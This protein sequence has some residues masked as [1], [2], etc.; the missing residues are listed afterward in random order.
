MPKRQLERVSRAALIRLVFS[1]ALVL[2]AACLVLSLTV[3]TDATP[4]RAEPFYTELPG[5]DFS[6]LSPE[7]KAALLKRLNR[8]RCPCDCMRTVASCRNHHDSCSMSLVEARQ[9]VEAARKQ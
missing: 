8:Q 5:I 2:G 3:W 6:G 1:L 4:A 9:A 7:K